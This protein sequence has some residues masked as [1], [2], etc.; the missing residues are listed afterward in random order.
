MAHVSMTLTRFAF[1]T[2][3]NFAYAIRTVKEKLNSE[4]VDE[5]IFFTRNDQRTSKLWGYDQSEEFVERNVI[6]LLFKDL[7]NWGYAKI[8]CEVKLLFVFHEKSFQHN[9]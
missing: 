1:A 7:M 8:L 5:M 6:L 9:A 2:K 3:M 4:L